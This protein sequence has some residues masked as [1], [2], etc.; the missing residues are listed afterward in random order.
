MLFSLLIRFVAEA[1]AMT[2]GWMR[3]GISFL[4]QR[5]HSQGLPALGVEVIII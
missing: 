4:L 1:S 5:S 3:K 2:S